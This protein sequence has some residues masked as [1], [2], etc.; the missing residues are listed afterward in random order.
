MGKIVPTEGVRYSGDGEVRF[1]EVCGYCLDF[2][3][4]VRTED[5]T[6]FKDVKRRRVFNMAMKEEAW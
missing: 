3:Y 5:L 6:N 1:G 2:G 4:V